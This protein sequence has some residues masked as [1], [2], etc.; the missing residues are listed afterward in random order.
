M[1]SL[2]MQEYLNPKLFRAGRWC[3]GFPAI[4]CVCVCVC[5]CV[6]V[7]VRMCACV[8][9]LCACA[10]ECMC[11]CVCAC[12][13]VCVLVCACT[14]ERVYFGVAAS[15]I[16]L[17]TRSFLS[18]S[19]C[20]F[21]FDYMCVFLYIRL[22]IIT[23]PAH[24]FPR[25]P[26]MLFF[27][28]IYVR[29]YIHVYIITYVHYH[30]LH[31]YIITVSAPSHPRLP[32][33]LL[34]D[35]IYISLS[36]YIHVYY[37]T[38]HKVSSQCVDVLHHALISRSFRMRGWTTEWENETARLRR[39]EQVRLYMEESWF[40]IDTLCEWEREWETKTA[41]LRRDERVRL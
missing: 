8:C 17:C 14:R 38:S 35:Y 25:L 37:I 26:V 33:M 12:V 18:S 4:L 34:F 7:R 28:Y 6:R 21:F 29:L 22:N 41:R 2:N 3:V 10:C 13:C 5:L 30:L 20:D 40:K 11:I 15:C 39:D 23:V 24:S 27:Q 16:R 1:G 36:L 9:M 31:M 32:V 19:S